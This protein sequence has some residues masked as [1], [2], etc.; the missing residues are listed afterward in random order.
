MVD[1][2][3][4]GCGY[5]RGGYRSAH[6]LRRG[7]ALQV[8]ARTD[9]HRVLRRRRSSRADPPAVVQQLLLPTRRRPRARARMDARYRHGRGV[10][11]PEHGRS[12]GADGR[13]DRRRVHRR[14]RPGRG[15]GRERPSSTDSA[16]TA[17]PSTIRGCP[18]GN[19]PTG[20]APTPTTFCSRCFA[21]RLR[22]RTAWTPGAS[23]GRQSAPPADCRAGVR[24]I[25]APFPIRLRQSA[26][27]ADCRA[28][29]GRGYGGNASRKWTS[30][31][32][33][34]ALDAH[35]GRFR[36]RHVRLRFL[37]VFDVQQEEDLIRRVHRAP[38]VQDGQTRRRARGRLGVEDALP[39]VGVLYAIANQQ[40]HR[41]SPKVRSALPP[42]SPGRE[43]G[44]ACGRRLDPYSPAGGAGISKACP[45]CLTVRTGQG[46]LRTTFS[47]TLPSSRCRTG[48]RPCVP[49][50]I[51]SIALSVA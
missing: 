50:T 37:P 28:G 51:R 43:A 41:D 40:Y 29:A 20:T 35:R 6:V 21:R 5:L 34:P 32:I 39:P 19:W 17:S 46:A 47:A 27:P 42:G 11:G 31:S 18:S 25:D 44:T 15:H 23:V 49:M 8:R 13:E 38:H 30:P 9:G 4:D 7:A 3:H 45:G 12:R 1:P 16:G 26:P 33:A 22:C 14:A 48:P 2:S 10:R 24:Y 36:R